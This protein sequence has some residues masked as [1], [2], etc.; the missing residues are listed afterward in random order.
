MHYC[1]GLLIQPPRRPPP[2][3]LAPGLPPVIKFVGALKTAAA[4]TADNIS[5]RIRATS[6]PH[7]STS[8]SDASASAKTSP[9]AGGRTG[10]GQSAVVRG[11]VEGGL[12]LDVPCGDIHAT[13]FDAVF[14]P[15]CLRGI[16]AAVQAGG[17]VSLRK[18]GLDRP[19]EPQAPGNKHKRD[20]ADAQGAED[21]RDK[22]EKALWPTCRGTR[23]DRLSSLVFLPSYLSA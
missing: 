23:D 13:I 20:G 3:P 1:T 15:P 2:L 19:S 5:Y 11:G 17:P 18:G 22:A 7:S 12:E 14:G 4:G 16:R 8:L 21:W 10:R 9:A 6:S